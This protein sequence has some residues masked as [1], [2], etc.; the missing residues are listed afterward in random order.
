[1][2]TLTYKGSVS[3]GGLCPAVVAAQAAV[4]ANLNAR[5]AGLIALQARLSLQPPSFALGL[6]AAAALKA[7][8]EAAITGGVVFPGVDVQIAALAALVATL[9]AQIALLI[10]GA[11]LGAGGVYVWE[12]DGTGPELGP[13]LTNALA[14][15]WPDGAS[16]LLPANA[17]VLATTIGATWAAMKT[18]FGGA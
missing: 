14:T 7:G 2:A 11:I 6:D 13:L 8:I 10:P 15:Q 18:F 9:E 4:L 16:P 17:I 1:M 12:F 5:I 3:I